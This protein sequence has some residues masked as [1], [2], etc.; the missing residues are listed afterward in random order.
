M[1]I[2]STKRDMRA[3]KNALLVDLFLRCSESVAL[4]SFDRAR[5]QREPQQLGKKYSEE[6][7]EIR[8]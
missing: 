7:R 5:A 3:T 2:A 1:M 6:E 4:Y 8:K